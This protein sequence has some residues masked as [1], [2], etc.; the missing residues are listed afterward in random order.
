MQDLLHFFVGEDESMEMRE[1]PVISTLDPKLLDYL[2]IAKSVPA[3][4]AAITLE[5]TSKNTTAS[6]WV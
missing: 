2:R 6:T 4:L 1:T 5:L 3:F